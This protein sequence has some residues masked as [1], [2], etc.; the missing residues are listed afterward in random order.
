MPIHPIL[1]DDG[2]VTLLEATRDD[3]LLYTYTLFLGDVGLRPVEPL[4]L[5]WEDI[6]LGARTGWTRNEKLGPRRFPISRRL[7]TAL[8]E[9][10]ASLGSPTFVFAGAARGRDRK[11]V[12]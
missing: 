9:Y 1:T 11:S 8:A 4:G 5:R 7:A 2:Y 3:P 6:D 12:V 10:G